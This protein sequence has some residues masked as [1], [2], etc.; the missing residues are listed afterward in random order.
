M[1]IEMGVQP[2]AFRD[3]SIEWLGYMLMPVSAC[4]IAID[5]ES[6]NNMEKKKK[7]R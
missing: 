5:T 4:P 2:T 7:F 6:T 3:T 1:A